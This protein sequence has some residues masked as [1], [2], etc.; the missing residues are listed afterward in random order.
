MIWKMNLMAEMTTGA[1]SIRYVKY[2]AKTS[3]KGI[4]MNICV[5]EE[6]PFSI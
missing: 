1:R 6:G 4:Q 3:R 5:V 2:S